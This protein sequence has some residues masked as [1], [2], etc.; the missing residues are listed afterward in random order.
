MPPGS[1]RVA[2][3]AVPAAEAVVVELSE[4][5]VICL[6]PNL[7]RYEVKYRFTRA[8]P[9]PESWY[10]AQLELDGVGFVGMRQIAGKDLKTEGTIRQDLRVFKEGAGAFKIHL[11]ESPGKNGPYTPASNTATG[12]VKPGATPAS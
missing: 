10:S 1:Y 8:Q 11:E 3:A 7:V 9:K 5:T 4:P 2:T 6:G 12:T